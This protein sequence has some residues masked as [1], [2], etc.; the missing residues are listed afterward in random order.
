MSPTH[1]DYSII[2]KYI[3]LYLFD[4][5]IMNFLPND[6]ILPPNDNFEIFKK[7]NINK[8]NLIGDCLYF[9][10]MKLL[11]FVDFIL[12]QIGEGSFGSVYLCFNGKVKTIN[13]VLIHHKGKQFRYFLSQMDAGM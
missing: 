4:L 5:I 8:Q 12:D 3:C 9:Y 6:N 13:I 11:I 1:K 7:K 2:I 10:L